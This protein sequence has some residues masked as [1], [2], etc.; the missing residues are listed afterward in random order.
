[1]RMLG[2]DPSALAL[3]AALDCAKDVSV[4]DVKEKLAGKGFAD[5]PYHLVADSAAFQLL[6]AHG[7][8]AEKSSCKKFLYVDLTANEWLPARVTIESVGGK[9]NMGDEPVFQDASVSSLSQLHQALRSAF[10]TKRWF[11]HPMQWVAVWTLMYM[12][13]AVACDG[14][15]QRVGLQHLCVMLKLFD[16]CKR[17]GISHHAAF[18]YDIYL[19]KKWHHQAERKDPD[20]NIGK[21]SEALGK[22]LWKQ[23]WLQWAS[24]ATT[25]PARP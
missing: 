4:L 10:T 21:G 24:V 3:A 16:E 2:N 14:L 13:T 7:K 12:P 19:R 9:S 22:E 8:Q 1:M 17:L 20:L 23:P 15:E 18:L 6:T 11:R 5:M 25:V